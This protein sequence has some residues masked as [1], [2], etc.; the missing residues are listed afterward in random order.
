M[1]VP[2]SNLFKLAYGK[3]AIG[4]YN[5]NN[6]E[7]TLGLFKGSIESQSPFIIQL[8]KERSLDVRFKYIDPSYMIRGV[9]ANL[10]DSIYCAHLAQK[11]CSCRNGRQNRSGNWTLA[12]TLCACANRPCCCRAQAGR[13]Q[14]G[15][16]AF[17]DRSN[18]PV[19][20]VQLADV[21]T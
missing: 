4:A 20:K 15:S 18:R 5:I 2:T 6:M 17:A 12:W 11:R 19:T 13:S 8:L 16:L 3:Y 9:P 21:N 7:Q 1:I 10:Q 14:R